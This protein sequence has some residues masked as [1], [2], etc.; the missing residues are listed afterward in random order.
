MSS[1]YA[2]NEADACIYC[3]HLD[4]TGRQAWGEG[5]AYSCPTV[6]DLWPV[7]PADVA[8]EL[9]CE[10]CHR[11][12]LLGETYTSDGD[13]RCLGCSRGYV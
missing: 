4:P 9:H 5:H 3:G 12:L 2:L 7:G 11:P 10:F 1:G 13:I 8:G 6:T